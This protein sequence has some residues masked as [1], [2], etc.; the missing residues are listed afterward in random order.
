METY[1]FHR[2]SGGARNSLFSLLGGPILLFK[3]NV[4]I[5]NLVVQQLPHISNDSNAHVPDRRELYL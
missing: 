3:K 1:A 5:S 4:W 2:N